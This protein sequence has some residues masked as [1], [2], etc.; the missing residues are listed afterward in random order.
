[1]LKRKGFVYLALVT[2][3][4]A[5][6][7]L[8]ASPAMAKAT[9]R[10]WC[11]GFAPHING[12]TALSKIFMEANPDIEIKV[13]GQAD[14]VTKIK[15]GIAAGVAADMFTPRGEDFLE[16][17]LAKA[18]TPVPD[19]I[20]SIEELKETMWP[21][22]YLQAPFDQV[23]AIGIPDPI[24][25]AGFA[26]NI[27]IFEEA[28]LEVLGKFDSLD[29]LLDY[30]QKLKKED[31]QGNLI[32]AGLSCREYN[33][34]VFFWDFVAE[35][36]GHF[37]D[38]ET[39]LFDYTIPEAKNALQFFYDLH[40]KYKV[41]DIK[42]PDSFDALSQQVAAMAFMW[43]EYVPFSK[44]NYPESNFGFIVKPAFVEGVDPMFSHVDSWNLAVYSKC[45][46]KDEA[47]KFLAYLKTPE[48]QGI[49]LQENPGIP[50][51]K[52]L[53]DDPFFE[54]ER[55]AFL[56][57]LTEFVPGM[58]FWG[59]FGND[60]IVKES[61]YKV[62]DAVEHQTLSVDDGLKQMTDECNHAIELFREKY[63]DFQKPDIQY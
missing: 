59:P 41:D 2:F 23:Y 6:M 24:G 12:Y 42:L 48:A 34:Q 39:D 36:G 8:T 49:F 63:P 19:E 20:L 54:T 62:M 16:F 17:V 22:Y 33:N 47:F 29:Q 50:P 51:L 40:Y 14:I 5:G 38:N 30:A 32:R 9:L 11:H 53:I 26:I 27:D 1:M 18:I 52:E 3:V 21:E 10:I 15:S 31:E 35:Q 45:K 44:I 7:L 60:S 61:L 37:Y 43:A 46:N 58:K 4:M 56:K 25:D 55:G 28:G 57:A 13:E